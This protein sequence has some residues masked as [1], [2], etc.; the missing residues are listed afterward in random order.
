[1]EKDKRAQRGAET[2]RD[3][4]YIPVAWIVAQIQDTCGAESSYYSKLL[5]KWREE[6]D[7][8]S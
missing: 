1:M 3:T 5:R 2:A 7:S 4:E 8:I 6:N